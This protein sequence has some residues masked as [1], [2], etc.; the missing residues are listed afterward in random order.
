MNP[1][2]LIL[3]S[4]KVFDGTKSALIKFV[5]KLMAQLGNPGSPNGVLAEPSEILDYKVRGGFASPMVGIQQVIG[6]IVLTDNIN[7]SM[8]PIE[9]VGQATITKAMVTIEKV[10]IRDRVQDGTTFAQVGGSSA[11][12]EMGDPENPNGQTIRKP[13]YDYKIAAKFDDPNFGINKPV[14]ISVRLFDELNYAVKATPTQATG[15]ILEAI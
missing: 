5:G 9:F 7:Y 14:Q 13:F 4:D 8:A 11:S 12:V 1:D 15:N 3:I 10:S 2:E 6:S